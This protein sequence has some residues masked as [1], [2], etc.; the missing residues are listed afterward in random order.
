MAWC[1]AIQVRDDSLTSLTRKSAFRAK[2]HSHVLFL[3]L[4]Q[5]D[6]MYHDKARNA[7]RE[8]SHNSDWTW[9][10]G[11]DFDTLWQIHCNLHPDRSMCSAMM[12]ICIRCDCLKVQV[13]KALGGS[14]RCALNHCFLAMLAWTIPCFRQASR[15]MFE[16][17]EYMLLCG[18]RLQCML[19]SVWGR[20]WV[21]SNKALLAD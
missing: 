16:V 7:R 14:C 3:L 2:M 15:C 11:V 17:S 10:F 8:T 5:K 21:K 18:W 12:I 1:T 6:S 9:S 19:Q 20:E 13:C 4:Q